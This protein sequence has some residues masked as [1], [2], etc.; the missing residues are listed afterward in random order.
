M[1]KIFPVFFIFK[2]TSLI[3]NEIIIKLYGVELIGKHKEQSEKKSVV[4][5][6]RENCF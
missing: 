6:C 1:F 4:L 5:P 3:M 2:H